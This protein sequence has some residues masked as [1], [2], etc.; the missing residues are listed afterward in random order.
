MT[1]LQPIRGRAPAGIRKSAIL[2][3]DGRPVNYFL[4]PSPRQNM[5]SYKPRAWLSTDT[6]VNVSEGDRYE[7]VNYSRQLFA[8]IDV[9][10]AAVNQRA[11]WAF[12]DAWDYHYAGENQKWGAEAENFINC[13]WMPNCNIRG[14][15]YDFKTSMVLSSI[16]W[17][18]DGDDAMVLTQTA[19]GFP[20]LAFYPATKISSTAKYGTQQKT[21]AMGTV[22]GGQ[23][24]G[25]KIFDGIIYDRN[26]RPIGLRIAGEDGQY[27]DVSSFNAD[28]AY[29]PQWADQARGIPKISTGLLRWMDLQDID[30]FLRRGVKRGASV[31]LIT[32]NEEGEAPVGNEAILGEDNPDPMRNMLDG[33]ALS[34][35][36]VAYEELEGGEMYYLSAPAGESIEALNYKNPHPNVEAFIERITR[37]CLASVGWYIELLDLQKTGRA[38]SRILCDLANQT[39]GARQRTGYRRWRRAVSYALAV[40]MKNGYLSRN[41]RGA[42]AYLM[43]P[44][45]PKPISVDAGN[46]ATADREALKLGLTNKSIVSQ[47]MHGLHYRR[48]DEQ[49]AIELRETIGR[50]VEL[51]KEFPQ[52]SVD[53]A[54]ELLEQRSPNP[55]AQ[56]PKTQPNSQPA[57]LQK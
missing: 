7:L 21:G 52:I 25:A 54:L 41:D 34:D 3:A 4:Y 45:M 6:K 8:Q 33:S 35:R 29:E 36:K 37:G 39:I 43:E 16:A 30:D 22:E 15:Q 14:P 47:K 53:R 56:S 46:E 31:G 17:D 9:L 28:L 23:F 55:M 26:S 40:G 32:K 2:G 19:G 44:G 57:P 50:A 18:V 20:Q 49:R 1:T 11:N 51:N 27:T 5:R 12:G 10:S 13:Q 38:P 42:D 24:D 48:V